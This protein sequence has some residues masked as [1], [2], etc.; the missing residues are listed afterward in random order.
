MTMAAPQPLAQRVPE[1]FKRRE[2]LFQEVHPD[3]E[4]ARSA[5]RLLAGVEGVLE[6]SATTPIRLEIAYDLA[7]ISLRDIESALE[8]VGFHLDSSLLSKV[9]RAVWYYAEDTQRANLG[10]DDP[11]NCARRIF[12]D[13]YTHHAHGCRDDRPEH[14]RQYW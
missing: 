13:A 7:R 1:L 9:R 4:Q 10:C 8:E 5:A 12:I 11:R 6:A 3:R 14:L 2:V